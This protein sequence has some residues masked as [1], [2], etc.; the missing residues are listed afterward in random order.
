MENEKNEIKNEENEFNYMKN[1]CFNIDNGKRTITDNLNKEYKS[2]IFGRRCPKF[3]PNITGFRNRYNY[4]NIIS[5]KKLT[6]LNDSYDNNTSLNKQRNKKFISYTP[7][8]RKFEGYSKFPRPKGPPLLNIA[9]YEIKEEL[10]RKVINHLNNYFSEDF[11]VQKDIIRKNEN[12]GLSYLTST[13]NEYDIIK[14]DIN[15]L[16]KLV[17]NNLDEIKIKYQLKKNLYKKDNIVKALN[18]YNTHLSEN[19]NAKTINGRVLNEPNPKI[20][21]YY[22]IINSMIKKNKN[23]KDNMKESKLKIKKL[24]IKLSSEDNNDLNSLN[25]DFKMGKIIK[26]KFGDY[27]SMKENEQ[28]EIITDINNNTN[29]EEKKNTEDIQVEI[30]E[31]NNEDNQNKENIEKNDNNENINDENKVPEEKIKSNEI[32]FISEISENEKKYLK[33]NNLNIK[34]INRIKDITEHNNKLLEGYYE[35]PL[36]ESKIF[37][38]PKVLRLKTEGDLYLENINLLKLTNK[39]AFFL[40]EKKEQY[41]LELLKKKL[42]N[43]AIN[44]NN[45]MKIKK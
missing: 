7:I 8:I 12:K 14:H 13:L 33:K 31:I 35:K 10:K 1:L 25:N 38:K 6:N 22:K 20:K 15:K 9:D 5:E 21:N 29:N 18:E 2:D 34:T 41:D 32:S 39:T 28:K 4:N 23:F 42:R 40:Q 11:S 3:L 36:D 19:R 30:N 24:N 16:Q 26:M 45:A 44:I 37:Q 17:K 43:Q 27:D